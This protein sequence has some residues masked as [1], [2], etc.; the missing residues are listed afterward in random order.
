MNWY[1]LIDWLID[2][3]GQRLRANRK[4]GRRQ[5]S[6]LRSRLRS[7]RLV[8]DFDI[9]VATLSCPLEEIVFF[10]IHF[11]VLIQSVQ[12]E[13]ATGCNP[14]HQLNWIKV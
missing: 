10:T 11:Q 12:L 1:E 13:T 6:R 9:E 7:R 4:K 3:E 2:F 8:Y 14:I 5:T